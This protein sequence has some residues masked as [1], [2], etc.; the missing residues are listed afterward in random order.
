MSKITISLEHY[1]KLVNK[2]NNTDKKLSSMEDYC[3]LLVKLNTVLKE[4]IVCNE[5]DID[6]LLFI[7]KKLSS[8]IK[9][10]SSKLVK[11]ELPVVVRV[12]EEITKIL[13]D[14]K[15][16]EEPKVTS[17]V[18]KNNEKQYGVIKYA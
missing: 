18:N 9:L 11:K 8:T 15:V 3:K 4:E 1:Q 12:K 13:T 16:H 2:V 5:S 7:N 6:S 17:V 14:T 10:L